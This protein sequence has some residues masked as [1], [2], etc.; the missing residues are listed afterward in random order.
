MPKAGLTIGLEWA[1]AHGPRPIGLFHGRSN[2]HPVQRL[3]WIDTSGEMESGALAFTTSLKNVPAFTSADVF[4]LV[5]LHAIAPHSKLNKG[6]KFFHEN[7]IF[8]YEGK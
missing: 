5:D 4:R 6:Y 7:Y 8:N 3:L 2:A 1:R